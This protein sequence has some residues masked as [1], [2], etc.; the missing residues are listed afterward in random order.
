MLFS[1]K[2]WRS[3]TSSPPSL[4][5]LPLAAALPSMLLMSSSSM[6]VSFS[7]FMP[8]ALAFISFALWGISFSEPEDLVPSFSK[9]RSARRTSAASSSICRSPTCPG[10]GADEADCP[11]PVF[12]DNS[13]SGF[14]TFSF[15]WGASAGLASGTSLPCCLTPSI[16]TR[17]SLSSSVISRCFSRC[18]ASCSR[19][20]P[21]WD[22]ST[23]LELGELSGLLLVGV[24][25]LLLA[26]SVSALRSCSWAVSS[27]SF[28]LLTC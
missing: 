27:C 7:M 18:T 6:A 24:S 9:A 20:S 19:R 23:L 16:W 3:P 12:C 14:T 25:V 8:L 1:S 4:L 11:G 22:F 5:T 2:S 13:G 21:T 17:S 26:V 10:A 28:R 15:V